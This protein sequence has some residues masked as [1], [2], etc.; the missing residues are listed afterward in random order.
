[1]SPPLATRTY[2]SSIIDYNPQER[3]DKTRI[4]VRG[5]QASEAIKFI[6][7]ALTDLQEAGGNVMTISLG[8]S[9][10]TDGSGKGKIKPTIRQY[11]KTCVLLFSVYPIY[12]YFFGSQGINVRET[13]DGG[14]LI[15]SLP[16]LRSPMSYD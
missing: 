3:Q 12:S 11:A 1:M 14:H 13:E 4:D 15:L 10:N 16:T 9:K 5:L 2:R 7:E 8:R 6:D